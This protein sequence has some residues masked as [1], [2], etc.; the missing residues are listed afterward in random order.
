MGVT[1][2]AIERIREQ[3]SSGVLGPGSK[4]PPEAA[5]A[6]A[7]GVSRSSVREAVKALVHARVLDVRQGD[8]TYVTSL[9]PRLLL[10]GM[11]L[12]VELIQDHQLLEVME[13]RRLLEPGA[14]ALAATRIGPEGLEVLRAHLE[15]MRAAAGDAEELVE[16]DAGFHDC[17]MA[18]TGNQTLESVLRGLSTATMRARI[19]RA[20]VESGA[21]ANTVAQHE[22]IY[23]AL[24]SGDSRLAEAAALVHVVTSEAWLREQLAL[25]VGSSSEHRHGHAGARR[26]VRTPATRTGHKTTSRVTRSTEE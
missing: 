13:V 2:V 5:L 12:A 8:G 20:A 26:A 1:D 4:L 10:D 9:E 16:H 14:T 24:E 15:L 3:I 11:S 7:L 23:R 18:A 6:R 22:D 25:N 17:V 21:A 19:W